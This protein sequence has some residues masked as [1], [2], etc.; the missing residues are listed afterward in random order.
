LILH[1]R[2][3]APGV[4]PEDRRAIVDS[5]YEEG[6]LYQT[7]QV[8]HIAHCYLFSSNFLPCVLFL[9]IL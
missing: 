6:L 2:H 5:W 3:L 8:T 1:C 7:P 9:L 4:V